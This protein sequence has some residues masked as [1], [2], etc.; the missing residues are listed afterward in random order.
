MSAPRATLSLDGEWSFVPDP[1]RLHSAETLPAGQPIQVPGC[2]EAQIAEPYGIVTGWYQRGFELPE[3]WQGHRAVLR[4]GAVMYECDVYLNGLP[5]GGHEGGYTPFELDVGP[6]LRPGPNKLDVRV[7]NPANIIDD[8]PVFPEADLRPL[9][10]AVAGLS[11]DHVPPLGEIPHGKQAWYSSQ[12]GLWQSVRLERRPAVALAPLRVQPDLGTRRAVVRWKLDSPGGTEL[13][14]GAVLRLE[15]LD[16]SGDSAAV[17]DNVPVARRSEGEVALQLDSVRLWDIDQPELYEVH[18]LLTAGDGAVLDTVSQRFGM[19]EIRTEAGRI[20]LNERPI[21]LLGV[22]DQD[23]Y[24]DTIST[25]PS[26]EFLDLQMRQ[27]REMG[28]NLVRCHIKVP[29]PAYL[30]A[31]DEAGI[32]VWCELPSWMRFSTRAADRGRQTL[33]TMVEELGNHP[34]VV[35]WTIINEDWGT[36]LRE[37]SRDRLW[38]R[39]TYDWLKRL[40]P[41]RLVVDNSACETSSTPNFHMRTD[42]ADFHVYFA[43]PDHAGRWRERIDDFA[44]RPPWLWSPHG[45]A[46]QVGDEPLVLSEFGSWGLPRPE[47]L[48]DGT[49]RGPWWL[50]TGRGHFLPEGWEDRFHTLGLDR[51]WPTVA[52]MAEATQWHQYESLQHQ[53]GEL[54]RHDSIQGYV[55]TELCDANWEANGLLDE[56]RGPKAFHAELASLNALVHVA[57]DFER[58]DYW[59]GERIE[60]DVTLSSYAEPADSA[61][62]RWWLEMDGHEP[63]ASSVPIGTWPEGGARVV[64]RLGIDVPSVDETTD[65]VLHIT[66]VDSVGVPL[67]RAAYRL[68]ILADPSR[69]GAPL[70]VGIVDPSGLYRLEQRVATL[71]HSLVAHSDSTVV[72]ATELDAELLERVEGGS[73]VLLLARSRESIPPDL[74]LA[75]PTAVHPRRLRHADWPGDRS[76]W[77][78]DW[79]TC[80][81][82]LRH[83]LVP[84]LPARN[85]LDFAYREVLPDHVLV[86]Y[87]PARHA[88][89]VTAGMFAGWIHAPAGLVWTFPQGRGRLT[90]TTF[91]VAPEAGPVATLLLDRLI[92]AAAAPAAGSTAAPGRVSLEVA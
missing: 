44:R 47:R 25:P 54:R 46:H 80:W 50:R 73:H 43:A 71:G 61:T 52:D 17:V 79:V 77:D 19:R 39:D 87:D 21:Y 13:P 78:G 27:M 62:L 15:V 5:I 64:G 53:I 31:A 75:R 89:E 1:G 29:D 8:Y 83:D 82:W 49:E 88:D 16:P 86:G 37:E 38:L 18:A 69:S 2:W 34:S 55:V 26:R 92:R 67:A 33:R 76:P 35:I 72:I 30:D 70:D 32:L 58:Q 9:E 65:A 20:L 24:P 85:P 4:F 68:A 23:L 7:T 28:I 74:I 10:R 36:R 45:D 51:V 60:A 11:G 41:T 66:V 90:V 48:L 3:G 6:H 12:S 57:A 81:S 91:R 84:G 42:L 59:S 22:L 56:R 63:A 40:D 14:P